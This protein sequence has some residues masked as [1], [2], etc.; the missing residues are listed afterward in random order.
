MF[1]SNMKNL[2]PV[3]KLGPFVEY[4]LS[5]FRLNSIPLTELMKLEH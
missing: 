2:C 5:C 3:L 1:C 4:S